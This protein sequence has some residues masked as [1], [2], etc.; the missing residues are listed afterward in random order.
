MLQVIKERLYVWYESIK[1][2]EK[3]YFFLSLLIIVLFFCS[4]GFYSILSIF[5]DK[6]KKIQ[7]VKY[8]LEEFYAL[9][10]KYN[11]SLINKRMYYKLLQNNCVPLF[12]LLQK[13]SDDLLIELND[14][15][16]SKRVILESTYIE[17][18]VILNVKNLLFN[19][20]YSFLEQ[21]ENNDIGIVKI[22]KLNFKLKLKDPLLLDI[23]IIVST[24]S[25]V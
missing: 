1:R 17:T 11:I 9:E 15:Q 18:S 23:C 20:V 12:A 6:M 3:D 7:K 14:L 22:T 2:Q 25:K 16:E 13:I 8:K 4:F 10:D 19:K 21:I 5:D 24:W